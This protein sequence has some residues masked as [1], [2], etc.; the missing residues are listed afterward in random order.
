MK[1]ESEA[2]KE[3]KIA[4]T[5]KVVDVPVQTAKAFELPNGEIVGFEEAFAWLCREV[6]EIRKVI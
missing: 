6:S 2:K 4:A 3:Q 5:I 1:E